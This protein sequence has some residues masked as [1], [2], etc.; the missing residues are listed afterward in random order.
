MFGKLEKTGKVQR[1]VGHS[2]QEE[3]NMAATVKL[4][5]YGKEKKMILTEKCSVGRNMT[6]KIR[7]E[8]IGL[9]VICTEKCSVGRKLTHTIQNGKTGLK[10]PE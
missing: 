9:K 8:Q 5:V 7:N 10:R 3:Q 2:S 4:C 6:H 1:F